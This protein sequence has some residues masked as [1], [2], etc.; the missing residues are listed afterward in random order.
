[1]Q[2]VG[3]CIAMV[4]IDRL[5]R[6]PLLLWGSA[7]SCAA[8]VALAAADALSSEVLLLAGMCAFI[9]AF[10]ISW[11]GTFWVLMSEVWPSG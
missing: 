3:V 2:L 8:M 5:G 1:M 10:S 4:L 7:V 11:A 6:R 9:T